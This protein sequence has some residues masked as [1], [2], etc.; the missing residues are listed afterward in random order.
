MKTD[1]LGM[2][3]SAAELAEYLRMIATLEIKRTRGTSAE[4]A[5]KRLTEVCALAREALE[6]YDKA[7]GRE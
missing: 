7:E 5:I 6:R 3:N 2:S 4:F 1:Y